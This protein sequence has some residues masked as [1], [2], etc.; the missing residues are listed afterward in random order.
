[1]GFILYCLGD[2]GRPKTKIHHEQSKKDSVNILP[3]VFE[4]QEEKIHA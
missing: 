2:R 3:I 1:M 4:E